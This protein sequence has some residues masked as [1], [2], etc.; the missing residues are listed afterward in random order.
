MNLIKALGAFVVAAL[1]ALAHP[2]EPQEWRLAWS[3]LVFPL[4][5]FTLGTA[6]SVGLAVLL[7]SGWDAVAIFVWLFYVWFCEPY[8][9]YIDPGEGVREQMYWVEHGGEE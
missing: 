3:M 7:P 2:E 1:K 6:V 5:V 4:A 8:M 9:F